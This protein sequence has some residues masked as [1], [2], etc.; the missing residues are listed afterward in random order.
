MYEAEHSTVL[1]KPL[2]VCSTSFLLP[3][4]KAWSRLPA[5]Y[6]LDFGAFGDWP[7]ILLSAGVGPLLFVI[8]L[9]DILPPETLSGVHA[10][11]EFLTPLLDTLRERLRIAPH[12]PTIVAWST[13]RPDSVI[14]SARKLSPWRAQARI[15]ENALE[16]LASEYASLLLLYL[17]HAFG[18]I[19]FKACFDL[20][21][22]FAARCRFS[23]AG[24]AAIDE[25][26]SLILRRIEA[27][28]KKVLVLDCD[29]TL[30]GGV[31]GEVGLQGLALGQDGLGRAYA[32]FQ[33]AVRRLAAQGIVIALASKNNETDVW[34][35]FD[36]HPGMVLKRADI[37]AWRI[38]WEEKP[39]NLLRLAADLDLSPDSFVFWD[40]NPLE[41][42]KMKLCVP[43]LSTTEVPADVA[44]WPA[45]L[46]SLDEFATLAVTTE[47]RHKNEQY[48]NR[49][50][51]V[52]N[53]RNAPNEM[54]FLRSIELTARNLP[55][56]SATVSRAAQLCTKTNQFNLRIARHNEAQLLN[57]A[58]EAGELAFLTHLADKFGDHGIVGLTLAVPD[59]TANAAFLDTFLLSCRVIGR[60][61]E[62]LMLDTLAHRLR[63]RGIG[64]LVAEYCPTERNIVAREFLISRGMRPL[65]DLVQKKRQHLAPLI[66]RFSRGGSLLVGDVNGLTSRFSELFIYAESVTT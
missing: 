45:L 15:L 59:T 23:A 12:V 52:S 25:A 13:W 11:S 62:D 47:D 54:H 2:R 14:R 58:C 26:A 49:S 29:N 32:D 65:A 30:W 53:L 40:D 50:A 17:D 21:N 24:L 19:G 56:S 42:A 4:N 7:T 28:R 41:R 46:D 55:I 36:E 61:L 34:K 37:A 57:L 48:R 6:N 31:V 20:R 5:S 44:T 22:W 60:H 38:D 43:D 39:E 8:V 3:G 16:E 66:D 63:R 10:D 1:A 33:R 27:A 18:T 9:E 64:Y 35:V 51:F